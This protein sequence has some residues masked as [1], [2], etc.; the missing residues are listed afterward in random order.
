MP[1]GAAAQQQEVEDG[2]LDAVLGGERAHEVFLILIRQLLHV[3]E[4]G[5]IDGMHGRTTFVVG[6]FVEQFVLEGFVI[7]VDMIQGHR[8]LV[9][10]EYL[11]LVEADS[12]VPGGVPGVQQRLCQDLRKRATRYG[13][14]ECA[15]AIETCVLALNHVAP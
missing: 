9:G 12:V 13:Y 10:E 6:N 2:K 3:V 7:A 4:M 8:A 1:V 14:L 11:P 15:M 5:A